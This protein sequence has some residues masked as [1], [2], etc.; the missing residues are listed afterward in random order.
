MSTDMTHKKTLL[1]YIFNVGTLSLLL[2]VIGGFIIFKNNPTL[3]DEQ[4]QTIKAEE[5]ACVI[6]RLTILNRQLQKSDL[7]TAKYNCESRVTAHMDI[8]KGANPARGSAVELGHK[9]G[10]PQQ[11]LPSKE[12]KTSKT[13]YYP[14][15]KENH[16]NRSFECFKDAQSN[17]D[18][19]LISYSYYDGI[20]MTA[21]SQTSSYKDANDISCDTEIYIDGKPMTQEQADEIYQKA[22]PEQAPAS[23]PR[24]ASIPTYDLSVAQ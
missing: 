18:T 8:L 5:S 13:E 15:N 23:A 17:Q 16:L 14:L 4:V 12:E 3:T 21:Y 24:G 7:E 22:Q 6:K 2:I 20:M 11:R 9:A 19:L 1:D 10:E